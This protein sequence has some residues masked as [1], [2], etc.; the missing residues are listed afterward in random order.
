MFC[1]GVL[2]ETMAFGDD[3]HTVHRF[4]WSYFADDKSIFD[5]VDVC[6]LGLDLPKMVICITSCLFCTL[7][8]YDSFLFYVQ[9]LW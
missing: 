4:V 3:L 8:A 2:D 7:S 6:C 1:P 5:H 9:K